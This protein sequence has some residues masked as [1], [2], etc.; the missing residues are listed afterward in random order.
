MAQSNTI[1]LRDLYFIQDNKH[2]RAFLKA[3]REVEEEG[4]EIQ[5]TQDVAVKISSIEKKSAKTQKA[6]ANTAKKQDLQGAT[7]AELSRMNRL[8]AKE[9]VKY[10]EANSVDM[11]DFKFWRQDEFNKIKEK[12]QKSRDEKNKFN[13]FSEP[14]KNNKDS[15]PFRP[16]GSLYDELFGL[17]DDDND[18]PVEDITL[19]TKT[20]Q[21]IEDI[22]GDE[23]GGSDSNKTEEEAKKTAV[24]KLKS[25]YVSIPGNR[26]RIE[27][28]KK[29]LQNILDE[30]QHKKDAVLESVQ[31]KEDDKSLEQVDSKTDDTSSAITVEVVAPEQ[32]L[33]EKVEEVEKPK[34]TVNRKP[35]GKSKKKKTLDADIKRYHKIKID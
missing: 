34:K 32:E 2:R 29:M 25:S 15:N 6:A 11:R 4:F 35:R 20:Y 21:Q 1:R 30:Q 22:I 18:E 27:Q 16:K 12:E 10:T 14:S 26:S 31:D 7:P 17:N 5:N 28:R 3:L 9:A 19:R 8:R 23:K 33:P 24:E 13:F